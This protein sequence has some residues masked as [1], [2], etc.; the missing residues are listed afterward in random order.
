MVYTEIL[1]RKIPYQSRSEKFKIIPIGDIHRGNV[2]CDEAK[3]R[4]TLQY[5]QDTPN[6]Y[7]IG[8][9]DYAEC[10]QV[11]DK[12]FDEKSID[13]NYRIAGISNLITTQMHDVVSDFMPIKDK[14]LGL[15]SGNHEETMRLR[16]K[17]DIMYE[18]G[19]RLDMFDKLMGY[20]GFIRLRFERQA[21]TVTT[22]T[23]FACH[24]FGAAR[25]SGAKVNRLEDVA[26][27]FNADIIL[28]GHE[29]EKIVAPPVL[30]LGLTQEGKLIEEEQYAIMTGSFLKGYV[31][32]ATTYIEK[33][34]YPPTDLGIVEITVVPDD[35]SI[36]ASI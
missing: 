16:Y 14:C 15:L 23:I 6:A 28:V 31:E 5:I 32:K 7:W 18:I 35:K 24:G 20:S 19:E 12:R 21:G 8:M 26:H 33:K 9:G 3:L 4:K 1:Q 17:R 11:D 10:I 36:T 13:P 27:A 22:F 29:H 25:K 30:R 2:G 34:M